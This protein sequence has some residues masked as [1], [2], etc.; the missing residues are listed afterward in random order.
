MISQNILRLQKALKAESIASLN[1]AFDPGAIDGEDGPKTQ[2]AL[3]A[4]KRAILPWALG[5]DVSKYQDKQLTWPILAANGI[6]F[7]FIKASDGLGKDLSFQKHSDGAKGVGILRGAYHFF[8]AN[9]PAKDQALLIATLSQGLELPVLLDVERDAPGPDGQDGTEDDI[10]THEQDVLVCCQEI[11]RLTHKKPILY[12]YGPF[13]TA[14]KIG[15]SSYALAI[16]DYRSGPPT[17]PFPWKTYKFHQYAGDNGRTIG[18]AGPI[19]LDRYRGTPQEMRA[20]VA[21]GC[22]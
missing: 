5:L 18:A 2:A 6:V 13:L 12:S 9:R 17:C 22:P 1:P 19:D 4:W 8:R 16:A 11:E 10:L 15:L 14:H 7:V 21:A 20:W 3:S